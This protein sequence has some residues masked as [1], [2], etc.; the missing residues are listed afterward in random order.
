MSTVAAE[1]GE[2]LGAQALPLNLVLELAETPLQAG[3]RKTEAID[4]HS[5]GS[6]KP[7]IRF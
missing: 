1:S 6:G 3:A 5:V 2:Y 7:L 4:S